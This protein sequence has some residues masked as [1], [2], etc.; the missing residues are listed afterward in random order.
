MKRLSFGQT[1]GDVVRLFELKKKYRNLIRPGD[2]DDKHLRAVAV[3]MEEERC[4][5]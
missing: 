1:K 2:T 3:E 5:D 4:K